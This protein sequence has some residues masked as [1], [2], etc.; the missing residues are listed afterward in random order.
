MIRKKIILICLLAVA[1]VAA[2][3][4]VSSIVYKDN[5]KKETERRLEA[6]FDKFIGYYYPYLR[7][8]S[9]AAA[10]YKLMQT[11]LMYDYLSYHKGRYINENV[12]YYYG[13]SFSMRDYSELV[14]F[15]EKAKMLYVCR[16]YG[17]IDSAPLSREEDRN[18]CHIILNSIG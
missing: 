10:I 2:T 4:C 8:L 9:D 17:P 11:S 14:S 1:F 7:D 5:E 12:N 13:G 18:S 6:R 15:L 3:I 16:A